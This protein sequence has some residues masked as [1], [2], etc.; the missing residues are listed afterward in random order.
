VTICL[1]TDDV[2]P[3]YFMMSSLCHNLKLKRY[4]E[5]SEHLGVNFWG[6]IVKGRQAYLINDTN[7]E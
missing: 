6:R 7:I 2:N 4:R 5:V 3:H 1:G